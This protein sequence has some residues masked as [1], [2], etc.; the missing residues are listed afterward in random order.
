[1]AHVARPATDP[2]LLLLTLALPVRAWGSFSRATGL[3]PGVAVPLEAPEG[4]PSPPVRNWRLS[5]TCVRSFK[6]LMSGSVCCPAQTETGGSHRVSWDQQHQPRPL[7]TKA[8][9]RAPEQQM[10]GL[11]W[12]VACSGSDPLAIP[13][14]TVLAPES[15]KLLLQNQGVADGRGGSDSVPLAAC[16]QVIPKGRSRNWKGGG[17]AGRS[18]PHW[19]VVQERDKLQKEP[20]RT[21]D[22]EGWRRQSFVMIS[23][24]T[25][26]HRGTGQAQPGH[27]R[28]QPHILRFKPRCGSRRLWMNDE[29]H[30]RSRCSPRQSRTGLEAA[31]GN[32]GGRGADRQAPW[33]RAQHGLPAEIRQAGCW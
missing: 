7:G 30:E 25:E 8:H 9:S 16:R 19:K 10:Q 24:D 2:A 12:P 32:Q 11:R 3:V 13:S 17:Q 14:S 15:Q 20:A 1:M 21:Q 28:C 27:H 31:A 23:V 29:R 33:A 4:V 18:S 6:P 22:C 26:K 5:E